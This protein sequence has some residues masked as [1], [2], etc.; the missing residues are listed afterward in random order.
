MNAPAYTL[1]NE[2]VTIIWEGK[3][4][5]VQKGA[6]Q[7]QSLRFAIL[8]EKW[9]DIPK[10]LTVAK[11]L[12]EWAKGKFTVNG[13]VISYD[14]DRLPQDINNRIL[15]MA[16][17]GED[18]TPVF[19]F[20]ERL[21]KNPSSRSV[22]QLWPFLEHRGIPL[23]TDGCFLAYKGVKDDYKDQYSG[24]VDNKPGVINEMPR[25]KISDDPN[26]ACHFGYHVGDLSYAKSFA[27]KVIVCKVDPADVVCVPYDES[28]RKMR[29]CKYEVIGNHNG[30][31]LPDTIY[32]GEPGY[33]ADDH[34]AY[35]TDDPDD[36]HE[37]ALEE[38]IDHEEDDEDEESA[39][40]KQERL[41]GR[42]KLMTVTVEP[43]GPD[44][45]ID[46][47]SGKISDLMTK[48]ADEG[49]KPVEEKHIPVCFFKY[50]KM[51]MEELMKEQ[52]SALRQYAT[53]GLQI[54]GASKIPGGK[55]ALISRILAVRA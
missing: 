12:S 6:P 27:P 47:G 25:N 24:T 44:S 30:C 52:I 37:E 41:G 15:Q 11:S 31:H 48:E 53:W 38:E 35:P 9:E 8:N 46:D 20:W 19:L 21:Q 4:H 28:Q 43:Q 5:T 55:V 42:G 23:T 54:I 32:T 29:V 45:V 17:K 22:K 49:L 14:G 2:S 10:H 3:P 26:E 33:P 7:F 1:T 50:S 13:E 40:D 36:G 51:G 34:D 39:D 18:P 16:G